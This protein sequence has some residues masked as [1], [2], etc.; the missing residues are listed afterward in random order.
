M[1]Q[2]TSSKNLW[3]AAP[4]Y[5]A[6]VVVVATV[7]GLALTREVWLKP[8]KSWLSAAP[9]TGDKHGQGAGGAAHEDDHGH[10]HAATDLDSIELSEQGRKNIGLRIA[11][12][13]TFEVT[14]P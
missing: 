13:F 12:T 4:R 14:F 11:P 8:I 3:H 7:V 10:A 9:A 2:A 6:I 1:A 5:L